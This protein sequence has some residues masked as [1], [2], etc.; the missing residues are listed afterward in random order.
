MGAHK[1]W[2]KKIARRSKYAGEL[3]KQQRTTM[4]KRDQLD[5][6]DQVQIRYPVIKRASMRRATSTQ[7]H[8]H[9]TRTNG[10]TPTIQRCSRGYRKMKVR[11]EMEAQGGEPI[12]VSPTAACP[13]KPFLAHF[14]YWTT[15]SFASSQTWCTS[16]TSPPALSLC[17]GILLGVGSVLLGL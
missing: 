7:A 14:P 4:N 3:E 13:C 9:T 11:S 5:Q 10:Q 12:L 15:L 16:R 1:I 2:F 6:V 17:E 8:T